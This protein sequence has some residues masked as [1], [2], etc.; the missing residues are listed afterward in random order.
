MKSKKLFLFFTIIFLSSYSYSQNYLEKFYQNFRTELHGLQINNSE[1]GG[2]YVL[3]ESRGETSTFFWGKDLWKLDSL[4][5]ILWV[6][7]VD[8]QEGATGHQSSGFAFSNDSF[9]YV[10]RHPVGCFSEGSIMKLDR[11]GNI[12]YTTDTIGITYPNSKIKSI[13]R[14]SNSDLIYGGYISQSSN[15]TVIA[16]YLARLNSDGTRRWE[17]RLDSLFPSKSIIEIKEFNDSTFIINL[18]DSSSFLVNDSGQIVPSNFPGGKFIICPSGGYFALGINTISK[19]D[20]NLTMLW[21]T[22]PLPNVTIASFEVNANENIF[23]T[24]KV[25]TCNGE[26]IVA[27]FDNTGVLIYSKMYGGDLNDEG[28]AIVGVDSNHIVAVGTHFIHKWFIHEAVNNDC[29]LIRTYTAQLRLVKLPTH[30]LTSE[31]IQSSSGQYD[32]CVTDS[33]ILRA[34]NGFIYNWS[35]GETSQQIVV[36]STQS[37]KLTITDMQGN[38]E[39]LPEFDSYKYANVDTQHFNDQIYTECTGSFYLCL[40]V[41]YNDTIYDRDYTWYFSTGSW[42]RP[43]YG[44]EVFGIPAST[45]YCVVSNVCSIDTSGRYIL[46]NTPPIVSLGNDTLICNQDS[47][48]IVPI[49]SGNFSYEWQDGSTNQFYW[50]SDSVP[51][52]IDTISVIVTDHEG[53]SNS[54]TLIVQFDN[55]VAV[56]ENYLRKDPVVYP[57]PFTNQIIIQIYNPPVAIKIVNAF[58]QIIFSKELLDNK[59]SLDLSDLKK[60]MYVVEISDKTFKIMKKVVKV[61]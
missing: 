24:G 42:D 31:G 41:D 38:S 17:E 47:T 4:G 35:T 32:M 8:G 5:N 40:G 2:F 18:S 27:G 16:P 11:L 9:L 20:T 56:Q 7:Y 10:I 43:R 59:T 50:A 61:D 13:C 48:L 1:E 46:Q 19:L 14:T 15:C 26:M 28:E 51:N 34:P 58:G 49:V 30:V 54:D 21:Q 45:Y 39:L 29:A 37:I 3:T 57:N 55:C 36:D 12:I 60:G 25:D 22:L 44:N 6:K 52:V 53:C 23:V 33:I